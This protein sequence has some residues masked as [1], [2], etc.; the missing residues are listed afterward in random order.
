MSSPG[1]ARIKEGACREKP[2]RNQET[3]TEIVNVRVIDGRKISSINAFAKAHIVIVSYNSQIT[4]PQTS[5]F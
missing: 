4:F 5:P 1:S 3:F 2:Y